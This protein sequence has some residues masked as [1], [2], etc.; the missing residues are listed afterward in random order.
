M[1]ALLAAIEG[2]GTALVV[3]THDPKVAALMTEC[4]RM[5]AGF[6]TATDPPRA[7]LP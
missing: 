4:W 5:E 1:R 6:L 7:A 2:G 3:A